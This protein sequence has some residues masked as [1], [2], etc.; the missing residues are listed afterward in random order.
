MAMVHP[1]EPE[2]QFIIDKIHQMKPTYEK[3]ERVCRLIVEEHP[4][5]RFIVIEKSEPS[6]HLDE[7]HICATNRLVCV[8]LR[9]EGKGDPS[10]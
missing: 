5:S 7:A 9:I 3:N 4:I 2:K 8:W 10:I 6:G 1:S